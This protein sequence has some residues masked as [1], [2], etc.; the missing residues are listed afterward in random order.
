LKYEVKD[1]VTSVESGGDSFTITPRSAES[2]R[3]PVVGNTITVTTRTGNVNV[4]AAGQIEVVGQAGNVIVVR[5]VS[6]TT[7]TSNDP[8]RYRPNGN[9]ITA[10]SN[11]I[12]ASQRVDNLKYISNIANMR[13]RIA[14]IGVNERQFLP[15]WMRTSQDG[16]IEEI[17]YVLAMPLCYC[18]PGTA[19]LIKENIE[20]ANFDFK[21]IDY[22][23]D[24]YIIDSLPDSQEEGFVL[25]AN[26]KFNV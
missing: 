9:V 3:I 2:I 24:R 4:A 13:K 6:F 15:L 14:E 20:N 26:Y 21:T 12:K 1:D 7:N 8:L 22:E 11:A 23:I 19:Q 17:D 25:F 18:K 10:D 5:S 16:N